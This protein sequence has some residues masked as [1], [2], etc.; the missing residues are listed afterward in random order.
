MAAGRPAGPYGDP[1]GMSGP[2]L[3]ES[4]EPGSET[5][6]RVTRGASGITW[7]V[8]AGPDATEELMRRLVALAWGAGALIDHRRA[9][10]DELESAAAS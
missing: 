8:I 10:R 7:S 2:E 9:R 3:L 4:A 5:R 6:V 1:R